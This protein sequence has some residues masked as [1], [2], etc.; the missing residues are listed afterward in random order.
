MKASLKWINEYVNIDDLN[1]NEL[2]NKMTLAGLEVES[3]SYLAQ[4]DKLVTGEVIDCQEHIESD[5]L[6]VCK[7]DI[8]D[9]ILQ[10]VCG[11]PNVQ[12][13]KLG[14]FD[15]IKRRIRNVESNGMI[16]SLSEL[17]GDDNI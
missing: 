7:V 14:W 15:A 3:I 4:G 16:C 9:E 13:D 6:H 8:G 12:K 17:G 5:H 11:A 10:I 2:A 1:I